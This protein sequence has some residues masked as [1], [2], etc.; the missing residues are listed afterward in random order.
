MPAQG[1]LEPSGRR[2]SDWAPWLPR[3]WGGR[4]SPA[5]AGPVVT[6]VPAVFPKVRG[7]EFSPEFI[8]PVPLTPSSVS[9]RPQISKKQGP[10]PA[11][12]GPSACFTS[13]HVGPP[14]APG[15][16]RQVPETCRER[17]RPAEPESREE[18]LPGHNACM[19]SYQCRFSEVSKMKRHPAPQGAA[20]VSRCSAGPATWGPRESARQDSLLLAPRRGRGEAFAP[21]LREMPAQRC[22]QAG[23]RERVRLPLHG[24]GPV[25]DRE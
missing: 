7:G 4:P 2:R 1:T 24:K 8:V 18:V 17:S 3:R 21:G 16:C 13:T 14:G 11:S 15:G 6:D 12:P 23:A 22:W 10:P 25:Q 19:F 20:A 9:L 5:P